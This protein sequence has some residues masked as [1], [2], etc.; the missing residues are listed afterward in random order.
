MKIRSSANQPKPLILISP[1]FQSKG[2]EFS[3]ASM[4]LSSRYPAAIAAC[5]GIPVSMAHTDSRELVAEYVHR[6]DG[7]LLT[8]GDDINPDIYGP[9]LHSSLKAKAIVT[10]DGGRRDLFELML[11]D[12]VFRQR[13]PLLAICR[14]HQILNVA[15]GGTLLVDIPTQK[16]SRINHRQMERKSEVVHSVRLTRG[17]LLAK[18]AKT[19]LLGVNSTHHQAVVKVAPVLRTVAQSAD[20][21]VEAMEL[22][23]GEQLP[24]LLS[25]QFHPER[26]MGKHA[27]HR[28]IFEAFIQASAE[29]KTQKL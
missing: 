3:D 2:V 13:K 23:S 21:I 4:S 10:E 19:Q 25:V 29:D 26:L 14:G 17:S 1:D 27:E 28:A 15:L 16:P 24:F 11:V 22:K 5:G 7:V 20:G 6:A 9:K 8:G 12:E 18:I